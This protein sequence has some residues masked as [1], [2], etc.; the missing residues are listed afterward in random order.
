MARVLVID[1]DADVAA[2]ISAI[3][4]SAA[5][6]PVC[7]TN[8]RPGVEW[9]REQPFDLIISDILMPEMEGIETIR[10]LRGLGG[11]TPIIAIS[12]STTF[13]ADFVLRAAERL[14]ASA[15]LRKPIRRAALLEKMGD[16]L[17]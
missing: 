3:L 9:H 14:G 1:D 5:H 16:L 4:R 6:D 17:G 13:D 2:A 7:A 11:D 12:G 15:V 10:T 8:G